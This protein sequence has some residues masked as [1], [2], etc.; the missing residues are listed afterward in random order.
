MKTESYWSQSST[1]PAY[2][3]MEKNIVADVVII[4]GGITGL[5]SAYLIAQAGR[6]VVILEK[7]KIGGGA[8]H[9]TTGFLTQIIDT[10]LTDLVTIHGEK[11]T[12]AILKSHAEAIDLIEEIAATERI[13]CDFKRCSNYIYASSAKEFEGLTAEYEEMKR[14]GLPVTLV[15]APLP[16]LRTLGYVELAE[17]AKF[18]PMKFMAGLLPVLD[19]LGVVIFEQTE[20]LSLTEENP[21]H[22]SVQTVSGLEVSVMWAISATYQPFGQPLGLFFKKGMYESYVIE[23]EIPAGVI[24]QGIYEDMQNPYHYFRIEAEKGHDAIII[25]GEDH[26]QDVPVDAEKNF[27]ALRKY[28]DH[29]L[30]GV[31]PIVRRRWSG[32]ILEPADGLPLIGP[33]KDPHLLFATGFS[34]NG[35]TYAGTAALIFRDMI[36]GKQHYAYS[37]YRADRSF[38]AKSLY[39]KAIDYGEELI[40][41]AGRNVWRKKD[42]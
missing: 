11:G 42:K 5:L 23:A 30:I 6:R 39:R 12:R 21:R 10:D 33:Y 35:M 3:A 18:H 38:K 41:G 9:L 28:L 26:R 22:L 14:L 29:I 8:T 25:G 24:P 31:S 13:D 34:G 15:N 27:A 40:R 17:Q 2:P 36:L 4:G 1:L 16:H 7:D 32:P 20:A 37:L 19:R